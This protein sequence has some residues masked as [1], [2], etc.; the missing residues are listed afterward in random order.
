MDTGPLVALVDRRDRYHEW[1]ST[2]LGPTAAPL[3]TCEPVLTE[4]CFL[5]QALRGGS[6]AVLELL[7][8]GA[9]LI[10]FSLGEEATAVARLL[11]RYSNVPMTWPTRAWSG[12]PNGS[13]RASWQRSTATSPSIA[14]TGRQIVPTIMPADLQAR[15]G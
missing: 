12:C 11:A 1:A 9:L 15:R 7:S 10:S 14:A 8:R 5:L 4:A 2:Q 6:A 3:L 13:R